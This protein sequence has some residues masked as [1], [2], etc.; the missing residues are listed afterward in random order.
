MNTPRLT[1]GDLAH[2]DV[3]WK[4][5]ND[6]DQIAKALK[7]PE[8]AVANSLSELREVRRVERRE[9]VNA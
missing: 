8:A 2:A 4:R 3:L 5:G 1:H 7:V 6:T 9:R